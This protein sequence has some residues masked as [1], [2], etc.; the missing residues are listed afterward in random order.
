MARLP[1]ACEYNP[2]RKI[3]NGEGGDGQMMRGVH[4]VEPSR[5]DEAIASAALAYPYHD[6]CRTM[7][8]G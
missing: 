5:A 2:H 6:G 8:G 3:G 4:A 7:S 1:I